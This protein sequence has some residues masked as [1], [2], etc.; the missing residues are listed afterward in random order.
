MTKASDFD[1]LEQLFTGK[2]DEEELTLHQAERLE[3]IRAT[4]AMLM[5]AK[6]SGQIVKKLN[7]VY[8]ISQAQAWRDIQLT[9]LLFGK[10]RKANKEF[11]RSIAENM[12]LETYRLARKDKDARG[13]A[14]ANRNYIEATGCNIE[15]PDLPDFEK[16]QPS[17]YPIVLDDAIR[18]L[19]LNFIGS[20]GSLDLT[21]L[22]Q[23][24]ESVPFTA[25]EPKGLD[26]A[27]DRQTP[28]AE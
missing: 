4:Q 22:I 27:G 13:M 14:A 8:G 2:I 9:E 28:S 26:P 23:H 7:K 17:L 10:L 11:K 18:K 24:A 1:R 15:D 25:V 20:G 16:L 3:R 21:K 6:G 19:L 5:D 12:A